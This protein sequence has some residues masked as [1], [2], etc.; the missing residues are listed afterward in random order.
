M[1]IICI[2][3]RESSACDNIPFTRNA[4]SD[5]DADS[6]DDSERNM[7]SHSIKKARAKTIQHRKQTK[8]GQD[9]EEQTGRERRKQGVSAD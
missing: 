8:I 5:G 6:Q 9:S 3:M 1:R 4:M 2:H 7:I